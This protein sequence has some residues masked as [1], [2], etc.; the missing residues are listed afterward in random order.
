MGFWVTNMIKT[1]PALP[2]SVVLSH[3]CLGQIGTPKGLWQRTD[4]SGGHVS[5][6]WLP[7]LYLMF[8]RPRIMTDPRWGRG[9]ALQAEGKLQAKM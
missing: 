6:N 7:S 4:L 5:L 1:F 3:G 2:L 9:R 8:L